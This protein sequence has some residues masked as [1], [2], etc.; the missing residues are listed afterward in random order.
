MLLGANIPCN[1]GWTSITPADCNNIQIVRRCVCVCLWVSVCVSLRRDKRTGRAS[2]LALETL[3]IE[4]DSMVSDTRQRPHCVLK[5]LETL[6]LFNRMTPHPAPCN[7]MI[8]IIQE[9]TFNTL[10]QCLFPQGPSINWIHCLAGCTGWKI[11]TKCSERVQ[12]DGDRVTVRSVWLRPPAAA[13]SAGPA[14]FSYGWP[15]FYFLWCCH[16]GKRHSVN[17][18][19][20]RLGCTR[21]HAHARMHSFRRRALKDTDLSVWSK[22]DCLTTERCRVLKRTN[23]KSF[24]VCF[25]LQTGA[26]GVK[27]NEWEKQ[28]WQ[29]APFKCLTYANEHRSKGKTKRR[30]A[31]A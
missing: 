2:W 26:K 16:R 5:H 15:Q 25:F 22:L 7:E 10:I 24:L 27:N 13:L 23:V 31:D 8:Q 14:P 19:R 17:R 12:R 9:A 18:S 20:A 21:T 3:P 11:I 6:L 28:R 30:R 29:E 1:T 4:C